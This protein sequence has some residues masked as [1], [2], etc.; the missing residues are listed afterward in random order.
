MFGISQKQWKSVLAS[1]LELD[2]EDEDIEHESKKEK[3]D[4]SIPPE[5]ETL[6]SEE[7]SEESGYGNVTEFADGMGEPPRDPG[8]EV[9]VSAFLEATER[10]ELSD[11]QRKLLDQIDKDRENILAQP[12]KVPPN[13][14]REKELS[15]RCFLNKLIC[16]NNWELTGKVN[17]MQRG[18]GH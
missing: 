1:N 4:T 15:K 2:D 6:I 5:T 9:S 16:F 10:S 7:G 12:V 3:T 11:V 14:A 17:I 13:K 8:P 18:R